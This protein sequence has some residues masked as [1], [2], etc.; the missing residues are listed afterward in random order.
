MARR[1]QMLTPFS[2]FLDFNTRKICLLARKQSI[3]I[4]YGTESGFHPIKVINL[5][6][7]KDLKQI[8][9]HVIYMKKNRVLINDLKIES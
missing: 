8:I 7:Y 4:I 5:V 9:L 1:Y 3:L 6:H 2:N